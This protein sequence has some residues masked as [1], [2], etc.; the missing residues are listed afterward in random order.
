MS[1]DSNEIK[2]ILLGETG[3]GKTNLIN[4]ITGG[5]F[6]G[7]TISSSSCTYK[8]GTYLAK[9]GK[10]YTYHLWD[11]A[12]QESYRSL[13]KIFVKNSKIVICVY[14]IDSLDT[15]KELDYWINFVKNEIGNN[16]YI[17]GIVGNKIDLYEKQEVSE[18][19]VKNFAEKMGYKFKVT[20]ALSDS[21]GFKEFLE[22]LL[23]DYLKNVDPNYNDDINKKSFS[24]DRNN[25]NNKKKKKWC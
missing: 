19:D 12:G 15:F 2:I 3:V 9:N 1:D 5:V 6:D 10:L 13:N 24:L 4:V 21:H 7:E 16:G 11:T 8:D 20:S 25:N 17:M 14:S 23:E 22:T 18:E